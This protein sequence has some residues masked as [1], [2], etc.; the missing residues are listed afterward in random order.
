MERGEPLR[1]GTSS[2]WGEGEVGSPPGS[3][4]LEWVLGGREGREGLYFALLP[5]RS[6]SWPPAKRMW[7]FS[8]LPPVLRSG[9][10]LGERVVGR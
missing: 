1:P 4:A 9:M 6:G 5:R 8:R 10:T 2:F 7:A 3:Y